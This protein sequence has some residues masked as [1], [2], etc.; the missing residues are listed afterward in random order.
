MP[1]LHRNIALSG[2]I[3][4][5]LIKTICTKLSARVV[6]CMCIM[7]AAL[8]ALGVSAT[9]AAAETRSLKLYYIH[10]KEKAVITFKRNGKY[11]QKGLQELNRF[12]RDW[13][14]NQPTKMDPRLFDLV[15]EVY[16]RSGGT[17]YINVV[18][19]FRSPETNGMLRSRTK[20]VAKSS[21]HTLGKAMDFYIPGVK[22]ARL[23]EIAMQMQ[24]GGVGFYPTSGS[25]FVHLDVGNVRA[26]P[27]MSRQELVRIFP[28]GNTI[29]LPADG[30]P[31][32][33]YEQAMV[34]YKRRV[35]SSSVQ[36]ASTAGAGPAGSSSGG[37]RKT[38]LAALFGGGDE[39]EDAESIATPQPASRSSAPAPVA[40][41]ADEEAPAA[42]VAVAS[43]TQAPAVADAPLPTARP[44][45]R[46]DAG[47][48][49]LAT[50]LY[51]PNRNAAQDA[52]QAA[53]LPTP[54]AAPAEQQFADLAQYS[55]PVPTLLGPRRMKGDADGSVMTASLGSEDMPGDVLAAHVPVPANRPAVAEALLASANANVDGQEDEADTQQ[56]SLSPVVVAALEQSGQ[57]ARSAITATAM[58]SAAQFPA[59]I[60]RTVSAQPAA[61]PV[62]AAKAE[63]A[64]ATRDEQAY[65]DAFDVKPRGNNSG[66]TAG[67]PTKG[68]RPS[69]QD[70]A[71][72]EKAMVS[73]G[74]LTQ[75]AISDWA[76]SQDKGVTGRA[77]KA[78]RVVNN[79][80]LSHDMSASA[81]TA[82]FR[83]GAAAIDSSRFSTPFKMP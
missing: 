30:K 4:R 35:S 81:A 67:L 52:L 12:L 2:K 48:T 70:A 80:M 53:T 37:K 39:D 22:L 10:T 14:R 13:R 49:G 31:L 38:L 20:G 45:F 34:D 26:W 72:S 46:N 24:I 65:G 36:V 62:Q 8:P 44:A 11:D 61:K 15:W 29:H 69:K 66:L 73:G 75:E 16:R 56:A 27:R 23:R 51:S 42:S 7:M 50:A 54:T 9:E 79:R 63:P 28:Q 71:V 6:T 64:A 58:P 76:L 83:P 1:N 60:N 78:P 3:A 25:P 55:I 19:A 5:G 33:G 17:D 59:A 32:P 57:D 40:Q 77:V 68:A 47:Q 82:S 74:R 21:Q 18:S 43:A 41:E